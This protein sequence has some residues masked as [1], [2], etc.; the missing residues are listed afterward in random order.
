MTHITDQHDS[1][2]FPISPIIHIGPLSLKRQ[3]ATPPPTEGHDEWL[4]RG[5]PF[6]SVMEGC[7]L[8]ATCKHT[9]KVPNTLAKGTSELY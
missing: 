8:S 3:Q 1:Y 6:Q 5:S 7:V 9:K 4:P 2:Y